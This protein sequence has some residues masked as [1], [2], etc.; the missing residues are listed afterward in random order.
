MAQSNSPGKIAAAKMQA[1]K[2]AQSR[3]TDSARWLFDFALKTDLS[4]LT[5]KELTDLVMEI[6]VVGRREAGDV[7]PPP[8]SI[9]PFTDF[10]TSD[11]RRQAT[12][13][14]ALQGW[15]RDQFKE[16]LAGRG[17]VLD[18]SL[19]P[20]RTIDIFK[21]RA[22]DKNLLGNTYVTSLL[23]I[24]KIAANRVAEREID[25]FGIC[26]SPRCQ[27]PFVAQRKNRAKYCSERCASYVNVMR[28]R[29][30][31]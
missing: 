24:L 17:W 15:L 23:D 26:A 16:A 12:T 10:L 29:D 30:R 3:V 21:T 13:M 6:A 11:A 8:F 20:Y 31:L 4:K 1:L 2:E 27:Q 22:R 28:S 18:S 14:G 25:R 9:D 5:E 19:M 7:L